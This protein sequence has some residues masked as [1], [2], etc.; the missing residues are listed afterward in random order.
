MAANS[1]KKRDFIFCVGWTVEKEDKL[2]LQKTRKYKQKYNQLNTAVR[3]HVRFYSEVTIY[4]PDFCEIQVAEIVTLKLSS[5]NT[6]VYRSASQLTS[7]MW[8]FAQ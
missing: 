3:L 8:S 2:V 4:H 7:L 1:R 5:R 6:S